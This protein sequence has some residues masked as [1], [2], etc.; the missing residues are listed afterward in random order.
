M[1]SQIRAIMESSLS[2]RYNINTGLPQLGM[3]VT[4][5]EMYSR[6]EECLSNLFGRTG[7]SL[8]RIEISFSDEIQESEC[9]SFA[10]VSS[11]IDG[12]Y[13]KKIEAGTHERV[14]GAVLSRMIMEDGQRALMMPTEKYSQ[15]H[16]IDRRISEIS[17]ALS[18]R[19]DII[20]LPEFAFPPPVSR[21]NEDGYL[22]RQN[23][24]RGFFKFEERLVEE[25][26]Q[27]NQESGIRNDP[28]I[29]AGSYHCPDDYYNIAVIFPQGEMSQINAKISCVDYGA[30][31]TRE[32]S[33]RSQ[34]IRT[35]L[36][37]RKRFP[38]RKAGEICR[39]P[40]EMKFYTYNFRGSKISVLICSDIVDLNQFMHLV[41]I[42]MAKNSLDP[43]DVILVPAY[44]LSEIHKSMCRELSFMAATTVVFVNANGEMPEVFP[45]S[46]LFCCG[47]D[48]TS[49]EKVLPKYGGSIV[50]DDTCKVDE[51]YIKNVRISKVGL[52]N[53]RQEFRHG[54]AR[55]NP[56]NRIVNV[57]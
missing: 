50:C 54:L 46:D 3:D 4:D 18:Y 29:V 26:R 55:R 12:D 2:G 43:I 11:A 15:K 5:D 21:R 27:L 37:H 1:K 9:I 57:I 52:Y 56:S 41:T 51:T 36:L 17:K 14:E 45:S 35:P 32:K 20:C 34:L 28:F 7:L 10:L 33:E 30:S 24:G 39:V 6:Y 53:L 49:L 19:P 25:I 16:W 13:R 8:D 48:L 40:S 22:E 42:N 47:Y 44:N 38:A 31:G 23:Y